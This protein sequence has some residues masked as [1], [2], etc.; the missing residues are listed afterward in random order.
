MATEALSSTPVTNLIAVP[1]VPNTSF[2]DIGIV[3]ESIGSVTVTSGTTTGSTYDLVRVPSNCRVSQVLLNNPAGSASSAFDIGV[4]SVNAVTQAL[5]A[6]AS[7]ALFGSAVACTNANVDLDVTGESTTYT[8]AKRE[9]PLWQAAG[10]T[11]D[12]GGE[13]AIVATNTATN[14][15]AFSI[16]LRVKFVI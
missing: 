8:N 6:V 5:G 3:R 15:A 4:Y 10:L 2:T 16:G 13:L 7:A 9:Q 14:A 11:A 12:P 1:R